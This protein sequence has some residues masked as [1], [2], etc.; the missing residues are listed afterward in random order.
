MSNLRLAI[1]Y[2]E[3][4]NYLLI[5][6]EQDKELAADIVNKAYNEFLENDSISNFE[7]Y[8]SDILRDSGIEFEF[9]IWNKETG[10]LEAEAE[11]LREIDNRVTDV[12]GGWL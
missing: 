1:P 8:A 12:C 9:S 2:D 6:K 5:V 10:Y 4:N 11:A 7:K 3:E